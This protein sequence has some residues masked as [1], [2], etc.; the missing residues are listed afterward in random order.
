MNNF[1]SLDS[2]ILYRCNLKYYD[3]VLAKYGIGY[4]QLIFL[5]FI[6]EKEGLTMN[7][8]VKSGAFDK[9]TVTKSLQKLEALGYININVS[10]NDKRNKLIFLTDKARDIMPVLHN[11]KNDWWNFIAI[12]LNEE[13]RKQFLLYTEKLISRA[14]DYDGVEFNEGSRI[15]IYDYQSLNL[16][17]FAPYIAFSIDVGIPLLIY[18]YDDAKK[19]EYLNENYNPIDDEVIYDILEKQNWL[20]GIVIKG[21]EVFSENNLEQLIINLKRYGM[22]IKIITYGLYPLQLK[23]FIEN[24]LVDYVSLIVLNDFDNYQKTLETDNYDSSAIVKSVEI[25]KNSDIDYDFNLTLIK[26]YHNFDNIKKISKCLSNSK[27]VI[28]QS[29]NCDELTV[30]DKDELKEIIDLFIKNG[31]TVQVKGE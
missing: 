1:M 16:N 9:G 3:K 2:S 10:A 22:P 12:D 18:K 29:C 27:L 20:E 11:F 19:L 25:L 26:E 14:L 8:L 30:Y 23:Y 15:K 31:S 4:A 28:D 6:N 21:G 24:H 13:E 17:D 5:I 7:D